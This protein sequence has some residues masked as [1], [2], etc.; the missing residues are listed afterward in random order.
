MDAEKAEK[1]ERIALFRFGVITPLL[2][3][4]GLGWGEREK[5]LHQITDTAWEI[6]GSARTTV[7]RST[8]LKWL[9]RYEQGGRAVDSLKPHER[10]DKGRGR[11]LDPES[12]LSLV[13]LR[14]QLPEVS[15]PV[16]L[17]EARRRNILGYEEV[18]L[19]S[20]YRIFKRHGLDTQRTLPEDR[21]RFETELPNDLW[22]SDC[23]HGPRVIDGGRLRKSYLF[24]FI[25]D[26]SR[27]V[28]HAQFYLSEN[29]DSF[30]DCLLQALQ[31][32]GLPRK[33]YVDNGAVFHNP[34]PQVRLRPPRHLPPTL[35][36]LHP[37]GTR[38]N[39]ALLQNP[40]LP[41]PPPPPGTPLPFAAQRPPPPLARHRLPPAPP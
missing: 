17:K 3:R 4:K 16:L 7:S 29:T 8:V 2:G 37:R 13:N 19:Q 39:R 9:S 38:E 15:V 25:D 14:R 28:P 32:R 35:N 41:I 31:T 10:G 24:A 33:L 23:L 34:P 40:P 27:L 6:P 18:S 5:I 11:V 12:E 1:S 22:Q 21:R 30:R 36:P 20:I 26:H